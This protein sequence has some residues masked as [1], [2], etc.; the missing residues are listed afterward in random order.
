MFIGG[1]L[2]YIGDHDAKAYENISTEKFFELLYKPILA[3]APSHIHTGLL[4]GSEQAVAMIAEELD[5]PYTVY[6]PFK[7]EFYSGRWSVADK[8]RYV[9]LRDSAADRWYAEDD[10]TPAYRQKLS[11]SVV[12]QLKEKCLEELCKNSSYIA[13]NI[14][15][16]E[17]MCYVMKA[18]TL[19]KSIV[20]LLGDK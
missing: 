9:L 10:Y 16:V 19:G 11:E 6:M 17:K 20:R 3:F 4:P 2:G 14:K 13:T 12:T 5:I 8:E 1:S 18:Y 7:R 15:S